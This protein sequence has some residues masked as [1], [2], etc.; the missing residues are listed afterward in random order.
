MRYLHEWSGVLR[1]LWMLSESVL[2]SCRVLPDGTIPNRLVTS[3]WNILLQ[4]SINNW[5]THATSLADDG[6]C[7]AGDRPGIWAF[8]MGA[9]SRDWPMQTLKLYA[10]IWLEA[11]WVVMWWRTHM[12]CRKRFKLLRGRRSTKLKEMC[13]DEIF[14][15]TAKSLQKIYFEKR[16]WTI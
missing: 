7:A 10:S 9:Q 12:M 16:Q 11:A 6:C 15:F 8:V 5:T 2:E 13:K 4:L 1:K 3:G 14:M